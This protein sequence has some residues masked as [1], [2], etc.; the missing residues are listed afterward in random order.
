LAPPGD[1]HYADKNGQDVLRKIDEIPRAVHGSDG[2]DLALGEIT[3]PAD[4]LK[5][6]IDERAIIPLLCVRFPNLA[7]RIRGLTSKL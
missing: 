6:L 7:Q 2:T 4:S 3:L 5:Q 1:M